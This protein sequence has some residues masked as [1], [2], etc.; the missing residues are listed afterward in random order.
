MGWS[1]EVGL[2][3]SFTSVRTLSGAYAAQ[4]AVLRLEAGAGAFF[5]KD[6]AEDGTLYFNGTY[7]KAYEI[8]RSKVWHR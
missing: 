5:D 2:S 1:Q 3:R 6:Q 7:Y 8:R 4:R